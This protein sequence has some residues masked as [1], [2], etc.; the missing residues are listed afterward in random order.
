MDWRNFV[1]A[2][3]VRRKRVQLPDR[4]RAVREFS[5]EVKQ[6]ERELSWSAKDEQ[7]AASMGGSNV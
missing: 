6:R 5:K 1:G 3:Q 7:N 2:S 4:R